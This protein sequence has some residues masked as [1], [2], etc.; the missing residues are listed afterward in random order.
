MLQQRVHG[1]GVP[2]AVLWQLAAP[3]DVRRLRARHQLP[4]APLRNA[5]HV[6]THRTGTTLYTT[7]VE[8]AGI[9]YILQA[10]I[11]G[12]FL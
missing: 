11:Q 12:N 3:A 9:Y 2:G 5:L 1:G 7:Q 6:R 10:C 8:T 4:R